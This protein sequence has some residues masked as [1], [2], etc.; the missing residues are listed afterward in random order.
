LIRAV[1]GGTLAGLVAAL[2]VA[3]PAS[4]HSADAPAASDYRCVVTGIS[5]PLPGLTVRTVS[6]GTEL[7]LVNR[8]ARTVEVL[9]YSGEPYLRVGPDGVYQNASS[10]STYLNE[11][12]TGGPNPPAPVTPAAAPVWQKLSGTPAVLWH[13]HRAHW[14][15]AGLPPVVAADPGAPHQISVWTVPLRDGVRPLTV[16][17]T[18]DWQPRPVPGAWWAG[19][20]LLAAGVAAL[21]LLRTPRALT[22]G[23]GIAAVAGLCA[24]GYAVGAARDSGALGALGVARAVVTVQPWPLLC[25]LAALAAAGYAAA[26]RPAADLALGLAGA[27]LALF[28][29]ISNAAVFAHAVPPAPLPGDMARAL[30]L[31]CIAG[32]AGLAG[33]AALR[34]RA[35]AASPPAAPPTAPPTLP[36]TVPPAASAA[37]AGGG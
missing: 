8:G 35:V 30:V 18:L 11:T 28:A 5:P 22:I 29:G 31:A 4:A 7:E 9:G 10:P 2:A 17:G 33:L 32:G 6:A 34:L 19:G 23:A 1:L 15:S 26:R 14:M 12:L 24:L 25:G 36:P 16:T 13:D 3:S 20:L 27:C 37:A 21:G